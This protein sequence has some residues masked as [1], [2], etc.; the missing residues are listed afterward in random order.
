[1]P[2]LRVFV[3]SAIAIAALLTVL[4]LKLAWSGASRRADAAGG[5]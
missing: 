1:M 4:L 2:M 3:Y 5:M